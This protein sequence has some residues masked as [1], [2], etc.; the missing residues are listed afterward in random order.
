M[1]HDKQTSI[2]IINIHLVSLTYFQLSVYMYWTEATKRNIELY[3]N[4]NQSITLIEVMKVENRRNYIV[5]RDYYKIYIFTIF[6]NIYF[7]VYLDMS[8]LSLSSN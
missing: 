3:N 4:K 1:L 2:I 6:V 8:I 5:V 7:D